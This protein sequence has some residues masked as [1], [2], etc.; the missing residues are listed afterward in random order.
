[1]ALWNIS[2]PKLRELGLVSHPDVAKAMYYNAARVMLTQLRSTTRGDQIE[3]DHQRDRQLIANYVM[4]KTGAIEIA[5]RN[6][7]HYVEVRDFD[8]MRQGVGM[9][10]AELM[11]IKAEGD[12]D[13]IK[14]LI[15]RYGVHF[16]P[17][18]RDEVVARY[19]RL[20]LPTY[21][22]GINPDLVLTTTSD[23][24]LGKFARVDITYPRDFMRQRLAY[25]A[26]YEPSLLAAGRGTLPQP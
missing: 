1:M 19:K 24:E 8:K 11:R 7:K 25:S 15:D 10:L 5:E 17:R 18:L 3:E 21:W 13:A 6:G 23:V 12:Y 22:A 26:M 9:L 20:D 2:D 14:A 16:D 4:D